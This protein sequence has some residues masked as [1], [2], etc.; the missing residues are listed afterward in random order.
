MSWVDASVAKVWI[1]QHALQTRESSGTSNGQYDEGLLES[2][3]NMVSNTVCPDLDHQHD[4]GHPAT[5]HPTQPTYA[6]E[7]DDS[8]TQST[9]VHWTG[10]TTKVSTSYKPCGV[11]EGERLHITRQHS[12]RTLTRTLSSNN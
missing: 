8:S 9:P 1:R 11:V 3:A 10:D 5:E 7:S 12:A 2:A 6:S 4:I